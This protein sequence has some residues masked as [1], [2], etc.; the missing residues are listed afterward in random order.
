MAPL[1]FRL[2][3]QL[4][5]M[6]IPDTQAHLDGHIILTYTYSIYNDTGKG[7]LKQS[8]SKESSLHL[9]HISDPDY[10][11][12]ITYEKPGEIFSYTPN[13]DRQLSRDEIKEIIAHLNNI[14]D[15]PATWKR[16]G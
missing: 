2:G 1:F 7:E 10:L 4:P 9:D 16:L 13:G 14:R 8:K 11:G 5:L 12:F 6:I 15:N 3:N